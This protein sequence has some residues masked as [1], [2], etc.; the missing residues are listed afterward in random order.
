MVGLG[1]KNDDGK[2]YHAIHQLCCQPPPKARRDHDFV[3]F[4]HVART[5]AYAAKSRAHRG[6]LINT[7]SRCSGAHSVNR[8]HHTFISGQADVMSELPP[9]LR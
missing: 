7:V 2:Q 5:T 3:A 6:A 4:T 1:K 9:H 8:Q